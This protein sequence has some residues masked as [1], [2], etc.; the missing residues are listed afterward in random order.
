MVTK[1]IGL[2]FLLV[3]ISVTGMSGCAGKGKGQQEAEPVRVPIR[4]VAILPIQTP[5]VFT[6]DKSEN[7][8]LFFGVIG[9]VIH[10]ASVSSKNNEFGNKMRE[11]TL[12]LGKD[13]MQ[14]LQE[15]LLAEKYEVVVLRDQDMGFADPSDFDYKKVNTDADAII[16]VIFKDAGVDSPHRSLSYKPRLNVDVNIISPRNQET[17]DDW[18]IDYGAN[19][20]KLDSGNIPADPKYAWPS[21]EAMMQKI[22][23]VV[24]GLQQGPKLLGPH[25]A[26]TLR[27]RNP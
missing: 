11:F 20:S 27:E 4:K 16:H 17:I 26:K 3:L 19:A 23:D 15:N 10:S 7:A 25:I 6:L 22:P 18:S 21:F 13:L 24:E 2:A 5:R 1:K 14:S 9:H 8:L 12:P